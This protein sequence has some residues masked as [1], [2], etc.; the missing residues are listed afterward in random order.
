MAKKKGGDD[1]SELFPEVNKIISL[2]SSE[3][4]QETVILVIP[5]HDRKNK[6]LN[7]VRVKEW[8]SQAMRLFADLYVGATAFETFKGIYKTEDGEYLLDNPILIESY[9]TVEAIESPDNLNQ[10]VRFAKRMGKDLNQAAV[11]LVIGQVM[12]YVT[13]YSGVED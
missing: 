6:E 7:D 3:A 5:S 10:L 8:A 2:L 12:F 9:A 1:Q 4:P 13:D 11:M